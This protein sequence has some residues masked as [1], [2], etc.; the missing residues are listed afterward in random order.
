MEHLFD[1][2]RPRKTA[3]RPISNGFWSVCTMHGMLLPKLPR[4][5]PH[6]HSTQ[7]SC[8]RTGGCPRQE[9]MSPLSR[10]HLVNENTKQGKNRGLI[11]FTIC[12]Y[13]KNSTFV[14]LLLL[15][16]AWLAPE[17]WST[18]Q[19]S[20]VG[21]QRPCRY[22]LCSSVVLAVRITSSDVYMSEKYTWTDGFWS[23]SLNTL[24][25]P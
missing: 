25:P 22:L 5:D 15:I 24:I 8:R 13:Y 14:V 21:P 7:P 2:R 17:N 10:L 20:G 4:E 1:V 19:A 16:R 12:R 18:F 11:V 23:G 3:S 6:L 9:A